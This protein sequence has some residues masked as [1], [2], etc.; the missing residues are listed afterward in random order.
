[1]AAVG[2][3][4]GGVRKRKGRGETGAAMADTVNKKPRSL[5]PHQRV[6]NTCK[7]CG[8]AGLCQHQRR[9]GTCK[10][11]GSEAHASK[12]N[13]QIQQVPSIIDDGSAAGGPDDAIKVKSEEVDGSYECL[14]CGESVR[15]TRALHCSQCTCPPFHQACVE[16]GVSTCPQCAQ[17]TVVPLRSAGVPD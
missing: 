8:G 6:R 17:P 11:C 3:G 12:P 2:A 10:E 13:A 1:M 15:R 5:C 16:G 4:S 7:E 14:I 9:R